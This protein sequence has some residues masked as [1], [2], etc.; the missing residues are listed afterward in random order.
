[1]HSS[2]MYTLFGPAMSFRTCR[3]DF[4]QNEHFKIS[5]SP[6]RGAIAVTPSLGGVRS[7]AAERACVLR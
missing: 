5:L 1:M 6:R 2:Q 7:R 4:E 3:C